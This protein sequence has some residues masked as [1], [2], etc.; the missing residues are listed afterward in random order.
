M[1]PPILP[2]FFLEIDYATIRHNADRWSLNPQQIATRE[3]DDGTTLLIIEPGR[4]YE[5]VGSSPGRSGPSFT[6]AFFVPC[7]ADWDFSGTVDEAD[8]TKFVGDW[9]DGISRTDLDRDG[10]IT[11][12]DV[13]TMRQL[14]DLGCYTPP[15]PE[16]DDE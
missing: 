6:G 5:F 10:K 7:V 3:L 12:N 9:E 16:D 4:A 14:V 2:L 13:A 11:K 1:F 8:F 15:P